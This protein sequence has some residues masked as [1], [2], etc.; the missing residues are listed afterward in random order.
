MTLDYLQD[1]D[2]A[3]DMLADELHAGQLTLILGA[4]VSHGLRLP[5]WGELVVTLETNAGLEPG[6]SDASADD[7]MRRMDT[8][9]RTVGDGEAFLDAVHAGLYGPAG[10]LAN[11]SYP[12]DMVEMRMLIA[13]GALVMSSRRG[14]VADVFTLN[15]DDVLD[16][17]LHLH[18]HRTQI[19]SELPDLH[20]GD[21]DVRI[22][23]F[24][25][26]LPL[27]TRYERSRWLLLT[28]A[29]LVKRLAEPTSSP[30]SAIMGA[31]F[32]SKTL[33]FVGTSMSDMD[34]DVILS[35]TADLVEGS[36]PLGFALGV[37][38]TDDRKAALKERGIVP[39]SLDD[40][41]DIPS[42]LLDV[43]QRAAD[44]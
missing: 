3:G 4:G 36:R 6:P 17:Y 22:H 26:F 1:P 44:I 10:H 2:T 33:L 13:L 34:V 7:L 12:E 29:Q 11:G 40:Y 19:I 28:R 23:H 42:F 16:W 39:V 18:G 30:W 20:R 38:L 9:R 37:N 8:V 32:L 21:V 27:M 41:G 31:E 14:S 25:G 15:F 35:R 5:S 24:H 43:C